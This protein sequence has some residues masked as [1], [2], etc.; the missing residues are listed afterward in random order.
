VTE[1]RN[2]ASRRYIKQ[3][4][5]CDVDRMHVERISINDT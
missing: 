2:N 1:R 4:L 5:T 3:K